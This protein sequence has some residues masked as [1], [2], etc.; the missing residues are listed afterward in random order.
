MRY[1]NIHFNA[2]LEKTIFKKTHIKN[3]WQVNSLCCHKVCN[4][5]NLNI[6]YFRRSHKTFGNL[7]LKSLY[8]FEECEKKNRIKKV[9]ENIYR[10]TSNKRRGRSFNF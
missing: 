5:S 2:T 7:V 8:S 3:K 4:R 9:D 10:I 1:H 6:M